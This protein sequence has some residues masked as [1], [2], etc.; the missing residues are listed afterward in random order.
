M[1][2]GALDRESDVRGRLSYQLKGHTARLMIEALS[3]QNPFFNREW[4]RF[5]CTF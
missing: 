3:V 5:K 4:Q 1:D 2:A